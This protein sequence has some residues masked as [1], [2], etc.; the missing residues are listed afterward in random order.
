MA[1]KLYGA[2]LAAYNAARAKKARKSKGS[3]MGSKKKKATRG[4]RSSRGAV[5][6][7]KVAVRRRPG[8]ASGFGA[9]AIN[10]RNALSKNT[11]VPAAAG[12]GAIIG[13]GIVMSKVGFLSKLTG[14]ASIAAQAAVST[15]V[16]ILAAKFAGPRIGWGALIAGWANVLGLGVARL[17][18]QASPGG[19]AAIQARAAGMAGLLPGP[20]TPV[21]MPDGSIAYVAA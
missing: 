13:T 10:F 19:P 17:R 5:R 3:S 15:G 12:M 18:A 16:A 4:K 14:W 8:T 7:V 11:L 6:T 20:G 21:T 9:G 2:A 1:R